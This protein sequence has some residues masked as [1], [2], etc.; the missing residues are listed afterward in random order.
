M[1]RQVRIEYPYAWYHVMSRGANRRV[2]FNNND[3]RRK[4]FNILQEAVNRY[5]IELHAYC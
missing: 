3:L 4:F 1:A 2:K 5:Q